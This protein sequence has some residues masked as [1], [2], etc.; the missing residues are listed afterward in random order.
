M[1]SKGASARPVEIFPARTGL[2]DKGVEVEANAVED[3]LDEVEEMAKP[4][5]KSTGRR[6]AIFRRKSNQG[7]AEDLPLLA[8]H[9]YREDA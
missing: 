7:A 2:K 8:G 5:V 4:S 3:E 1:R 6:G 9:A